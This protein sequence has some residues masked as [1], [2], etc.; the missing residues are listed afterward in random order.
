MP[1]DLIGADLDELDAIA[2]D[3]ELDSLASGEEIVGADLYDLD[4]IAGALGLDDELDAIAGLEED[5]D[6]LAGAD[7]PYNAVN[8]LLMGTAGALVP[9][10]RARPN[11]FGPFPIPPGFGRRRAAP[12]PVRRAAIQRIARTVQGLNQNLARERQRTARAIQIARRAHQAGVGGRVVPS[13]SGGTRTLVERQPQL[14]GEVPLPFDSGEPIPAGQTRTIT[15]RPQ[16]RFKPKRLI[17][18][19]TDGV[20]FRVNSI[21]VGRNSE[22]AASGGFGA[23]VF[24]EQSNVPLGLRTAQ[25]GNDI[26]ISVTNIS[27]ADHTFSAMMIGDAVD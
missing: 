2:G 14:A 1:I 16:V 27:S 21:S 7:D 18:P 20:N 6:V 10:G 19:S 4:A 22:F 3:D 25:V 8:A 23:L 13:L 26:S 15:T 5:L 24:S 12:S 11:R 9:R 17:I